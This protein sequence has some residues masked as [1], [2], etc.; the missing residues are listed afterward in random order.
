MCFYI[1]VWQRR[2]KWSLVLWY[3]IIDMQNSYTTT[4]G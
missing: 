3:Q 2:E 1:I 4:L